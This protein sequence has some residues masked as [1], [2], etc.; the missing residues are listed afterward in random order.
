[1]YA[2][3]NIRTRACVYFRS[4]VCVCVCLC[5][6]VHMQDY[7]SDSYHDYQTIKLYRF[8]LSDLFGF[9][10]SS[11]LPIP[12]HDLKRW[13]LG[14]WPN[15]HHVNT[16]ILRKCCPSRSG[17]RTNFLPWYW[18]LKTSITLIAAVP[19][20]FAFRAFFVLAINWPLYLFFSLSLTLLVIFF[21]LLCRIDYR[22]YW[23]KN[24]LAV[25]L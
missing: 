24:I 7:L 5:V 15:S 17:H 22:Q 8:F 13:L 11:F 6:N 20:Y 1:M 19:F 9:L 16:N 18:P 21:I 25:K 3:T 2:R 10:S 14:S 4:C 23:I 12:P